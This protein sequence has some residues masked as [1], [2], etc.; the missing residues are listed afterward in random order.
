MGN[1]DKLQSLLTSKKIKDSQQIDTIR[2]DITK[3]G[4]LDELIKSGWVDE[5]RY[6]ILRWMGVC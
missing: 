1:A 2:E 6:C 3:N 4:E 5:I